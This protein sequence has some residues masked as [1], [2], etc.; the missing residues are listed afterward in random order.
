MSKLGCALGIPI[1]TDKVIKEKSALNYA[2]LLVDR[3]MEGPFPKYIDFINDWDVVVRQ[4]IKY[5]WKPIT[6]N[7]CH[8]EGHEEKGCRREHKV[9]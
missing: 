3:P 4:P 2:C 5:E 9:R 8:M 1:K 7:H 6:C